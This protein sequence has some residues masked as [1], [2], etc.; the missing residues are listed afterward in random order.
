M[1]PSG[2]FIQAL[3]IISRQRMNER[4]MVGA[5]GGSIIA[6]QPNGW[7]SEEILFLIWLQH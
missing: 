5:P 7:I 6:A 2:R 3:L 4:F 1:K